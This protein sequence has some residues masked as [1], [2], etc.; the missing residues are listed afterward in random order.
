MPRV[1]GPF[2]IIEKV[3][4]NAY[5]VDLPGD[6]NVSATFNVKDMTLYLDDIDDTDLRTNHSQ[7]GA[8]DVHHWDYNLSRKAELNLQEDSDDPITKARAKQL[9]RA[10]TSQIG[11]IGVASK[12]KASNLFGIGSN[13][14]ICPTIKTWTWESP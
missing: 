14:L 2:R 5:K 12:L 8:D 3:N 10:L 6:Y 11:M 4:D 9:Q 7:P 1:D 13:F